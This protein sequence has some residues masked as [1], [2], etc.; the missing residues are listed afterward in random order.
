MSDDWCLVGR[1]AGSDDD[2]PD[3]DAMLGRCMPGDH[4]SAPR[5]GGIYRHH[6]ILLSAKEVWHVNAGIMS[7]PLV[8]LGLRPAMVRVDPVRR[9]L[10]GAPSL[11]RETAGAVANPERLRASTGATTEYHLFQNNCE[12][13][14]TG[15]DGDGRVSWQSRRVALAVAVAAVTTAVAGG[16]AGMTVLLSLGSRVAD[17]VAPLACH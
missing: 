1:E 7:G 4:V 5:A 13:H 15:A 14:A 12:H 17:G 16:V 3:V 9:F 8:C 10:K 2:D 11:T 6:G